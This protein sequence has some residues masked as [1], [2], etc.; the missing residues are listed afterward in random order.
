MALSVPTRR[1]VQLLE[2]GPRKRRVFSRPIARAGPAAL[3]RCPRPRICTLG[4]SLEVSAPRTV[5]CRVR[6]LRGY[7]VRRECCDSAMLYGG[8]VQ[9]T[10]LVCTP[11]GAAA[12]SGGGVGGDAKPAGSS[13]PEACV[14]GVVTG[15]AVSEAGSWPTGEDVRRPRQSAEAPA[16]CAGAES[17]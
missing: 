17:V 9:G 1:A 12:G 13:V 15:P 14:V 6:C 5:S 16:L 3:A 10:T 7:A 4:A 8:G 2:V 11:W